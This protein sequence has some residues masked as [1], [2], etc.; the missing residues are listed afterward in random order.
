MATGV[1]KESTGRIL[2]MA[3]GNM[4]AVADSPLE[5]GQHSGSRW[6]IRIVTT[7]VSL[8]LV[9]LVAVGVSMAWEEYD[10]SVV[11]RRVNSLGTQGL[12]AMKAKDYVTA[13]QF[14]TRLISESPRN[15]RAHYERGVSQYHKG[16]IKQ[17]LVDVE[18]AV[19][20]RPGN[21]RYARGQRVVTEKLRSQSEWRPAKHEQIQ[22]RS[23]Q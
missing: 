2:R 12:Q 4:P 14:F 1:D 15:A 11:A 7:V 19:A 16:A 22:R 3:F 10:R 8:S 6:Q 18:K 9:A 20:L 13:C 21:L 5:P 23:R 17:A